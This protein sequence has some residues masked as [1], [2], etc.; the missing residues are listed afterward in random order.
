MKRQI[1]LNITPKLQGFK[2]W[3]G[4]DAALMIDWESALRVEENMNVN[5]MLSVI[6]R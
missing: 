4:L 2:F 3:M 1:D 6:Y 5:Q